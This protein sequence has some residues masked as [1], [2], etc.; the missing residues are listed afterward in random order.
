MASK[1]LNDTTVK[2]T[3]TSNIAKLSNADKRAQYQKA[4]GVSDE[5]LADTKIKDITEFL[6]QEEVTRLIA[7]NADEILADIEQLTTSENGSNIATFLQSGANAFSPE[8][9]AELQGL[10]AQDLHDIYKGNEEIFTEYGYE[11]VFAFI[12]AF[13]K[14]LEEY[15]PKIYWENQ[16]TQI[17][18][19]L[20]DFGSSIST[21]LTGGELSDDQNKAL[22]EL[23][24]KYTDL[25]A[26]QDR[27]SS[28]YLERLI[29]IREALEEEQITSI[30]NKV[31]WLANR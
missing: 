14:G 11:S 27:S 22:D 30:L 15:D 19:E 23:E 28:T 5:E 29:Q 18:A 12:N 16:L 7:E 3:A 4:T 26:I 20:E 31:C 13:D 25:A 2:S 6:I 21:L 1:E 9:I 8:Q 17:K 10:N 24:S